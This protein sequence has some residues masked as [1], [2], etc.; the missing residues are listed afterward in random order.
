M[1][2]FK[3]FDFEGLCRAQKAHPVVPVIALSRLQEWG[4][5]RSVDMVNARVEMMER[6]ATD[7]L[8]HSYQPPAWRRIDLEV[9]RK[10]L[11]CPG[12]C[13]ELFVL[14]GHDSGKT[15]G[16]VMRMTRHFFYTHKAWVWGLHSTETSSKT[17]HQARVW[18]FIPPELKDKVGDTGGMKRKLDTKF[19]YGEGD[20][21][22]NNKF[23]V[24]WEV[25]NYRGTGKLMYCGGL[26]EFK[27]FASK[28]ENLQGSKLT[29][30]NSDELVDESVAK[31]VKQRL[32]PRARETAEPEF[33]ELVRRC[34]V[35]LES[36]GFD[37]DGCPRRQLPADLQ[38]LLYTG[39]HIMG[40]TPMEGYSPL[41][42]SA[43][44]GAQ[45]TCLVDAKLLPLRGEG[46][47]PK[48][49]VDGKVMYKQVPRFKQPKEK[50]RLVAY[51]HT[52]DNPWT[53]LEGKIED[54]VGKDERYIRITYYGDVGK[55]W[56]VQ[57]SPPFNEL[58]HVIRDRA[59]VPRRGTWRLVLD[60]ARSRPWFM[61]FFLTDA[62]KRRFLMREWPQ[63][64]AAIPGVGDPGAW[65]VISKHGKING[66]RGPAQQLS[67]GW[68]FAQYWREIFRMQLQLGEWWYEGEKGQGAREKGQGS[69]GVM[70]CGSDGSARGLP[71]SATRMSPLPANGN[72]DQ[73][74]QPQS[75][76]AVG[77]VK[78]SWEK[79]PEWTMEGSPVLL[80]EIIVDPRF[81][82]TGSA[83]ADGEQDYLQGL[84]AA[85][86]EVTIEGAPH[87]VK[88]LKG[89]WIHGASGKH[90]E[91]GDGLIIN[92]LGGGY[93]AETF[94]PQRPDAMNCPTF[95]IWHECAASIFTMQ[96]FSIE[97]FRADTVKKDEACKDPRD[98]IAMHEL[99][100]PEDVT[101]GSAKVGYVQVGGAGG[102]GEWEDEFGHRG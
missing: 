26:Q 76:G 49:G 14:G 35:I 41:V 12:A 59:L 69:G 67:L 46:G 98:V 97:P 85:L 54:C 90:L 7:R 77:R 79:H 51:L 80:E 9:A 75:A 3:S 8:R 18:D 100:G 1:S 31:T 22:T 16:A 39:V 45:A 56:A 17:I 95:R 50:S 6:M 101:S 40:F 61:G 28:T 33:L 89:V 36:D 34:L 71:A 86:E 94:N 55:D 93:N 37:E 13:I 73:R 70:E 43:L 83:V 15:D 24:H 99:S 19:K 64:G 57:F 29:S 72:R 11:E 82:R 42:A 53:N 5:Q 30:A 60:P 38:G 27:F 47:Q 32:I 58:H 63:E 66:D 62:Q 23:N 65:A 81:C 92:A 91:I 102:G 4:P 68:G 87:V 52:H 10:R 74:S 96:N 21:F 20:G 88:Q 44:D 48:V 2:D 25:P 78:I 84:E